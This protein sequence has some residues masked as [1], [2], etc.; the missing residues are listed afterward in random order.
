MNLNP[1]DLGE[2]IDGQMEMA[3]DYDFTYVRGP[4]PIALRPRIITEEKILAL[5]RYSGKLWKDCLTLEKMWTNGEIADLIT[6]DGNELEMAQLQPWNGSRAIIASDGLFNFGANP[7]SKLWQ[8]LP[9]A[10]N[11]F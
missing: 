7:K 8:R 9:A 1:A 10:I 2:V 6:S 5:N 11:L 4:I 3:R